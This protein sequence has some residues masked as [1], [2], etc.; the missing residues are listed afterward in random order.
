M[1]SSHAMTTFTESSDS[2]LDLPGTNPIEETSLFI[3]GGLLRTGA[4]ARY[5]ELL[6]GISTRQ[7]PDGD[8]WNLSARRGS[9]QHPPDL[10]VALRNREK[11]ARLLGVSLDLMVGCRQVHGTLVARVTMADAGRGLLP[12]APSIEDADG[13]V[14]D[15][16]GLALFVLS[17]D[18]P[19]VFL[20]DPTRRVIGLVHSGWKGTV[21]RIAANAVDVIKNYYACN[22][23]DIVAAVGPGIGPCCYNVGENVIEAAQD[24]FPEAWIGDIPVLERRGDETYFNLRES[25][26]RT[27]LDAGVAPDNITVEPV[28]TSHNRQLFYSH[29]GDQGQCGLFGAVLGLRSA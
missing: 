24:A 1:K 11:L 18:C 13:M 16:P 20:Y 29:R 21:G 26:R 10:A 27:L 6:H 15:A 19:P 25:I 22:P 17:A 28:C 7:S 9:P 14:T 3:K 5:P 23:A 4:F 8:D 2:A 12:G